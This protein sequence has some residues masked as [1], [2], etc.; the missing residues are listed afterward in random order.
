VPAACRFEP[1]GIAPDRT[2]VLADLTISAF[3]GAA[4]LSRC[5]AAGQV[6][7]H[8][9]YDAGLAQRPSRGCAECPV[10]EDKCL[11]RHPSRH[12][13]RSSPLCC[14]CQVAARVF[15]EAFAD[16]GVPAV[17]PGRIVGA[18]PAVACPKSWRA[19]CEPA[20]LES[21]PFPVVL[22]GP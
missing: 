8:G 22:P 21:E 7:R 11:G 6:L 16:E 20:A 1:L 10:L 3:E 15:L 19:G 13:C 5:P 17:M 9:S 4:V 2:A 12:A 14:C 18:G